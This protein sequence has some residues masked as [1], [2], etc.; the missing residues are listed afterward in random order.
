MDLNLLV[1]LDAIIRERSVTRAGQEVGLSQP[2]TSA[3]LRRL[4]LMFGDPLIERSGGQVRLSPLALSLAGQIRQTLRSIE[5]MVGGEG[6]FEPESSKRSFRI[7]AADDMVNTIIQP[8]LRG[9]RQIAPGI[10]LQIR[11]PDPKTEK[12]LTSGQVELSIEPADRYRGR[13][14]ARAAL[15][16]ERFVC[17]V[18]RGNTAI[19]PTLTEEEFLTTPHVTFSMPPYGFTM[20]DYVLGARASMVPS[21]VLVDSFVSMLTLLRGTDMIALVQERLGK[22]LAQTAEVRLLEPPIALHE[23]AFN[24]WWSPRFDHDLAHA[25]LRSQVLAVAKSLEPLTVDSCI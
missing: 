13:D 8:L 5:N 16:R 4:R 25:W 14:L 15:F 11:N 23:L 19:G 22:Q 10:V 6:T 20:L 7:A 24:L 3:A 2:A 1:I 21:P 9:L 17:A 18:W 12:R